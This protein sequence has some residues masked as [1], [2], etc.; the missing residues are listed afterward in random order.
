[1]CACDV[2]HVSTRNEVHQHA[3]ALLHTTVAVVSRVSAVF[4]GPN[5][6]DNFQDLNSPQSVPTAYQLG[7]GTH[8]RAPKLSRHVSISGQHPP[9]WIPR[10]A[11]LPRAVARTRR[12]QFRGRPR[13]IRAPAYRQ[14]RRETDEQR[15]HGGTRQPLLTTTAA[16][17]AFTPTRLNHRKRAAGS[18]RGPR[19]CEL[20]VAY[21]QTSRISIPQ[22]WFKRP[23][24][25]ALPLKIQGG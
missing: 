13:N 9:D 4:P 3:Q 17:A 18:G 1:M 16:I 23:P 11:N 24:C 12:P 21:L 2:L 25:D 8:R 5:T 15:H 19:Q 6:T 20:V 10:F 14:G 7:G 22:V